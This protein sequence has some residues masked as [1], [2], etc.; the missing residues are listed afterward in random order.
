MKKFILLFGL[1]ILF[2]S[3]NRTKPANT[4]KQQKTVST[5]TNYKGTASITQGIAKIVNQD[6]FICEGGRKTDVGVIKSTDGKEWTV[7]TNT[8]FNNE[9]FLFASDL[10]NDCNGNSYANIEEAISKLNSLNIVE[11]DKDGELFSAYIFADNYFEMYVNGVP[12]GKDKVPFTKFNSSIVRFKAKKPFT[13]AMKLVDWEEGL[14]IGTEKNRRS[15][16]HAGD[17]G[18]VTVV[19]D[20]NNNIVAVTNESW[21]AQT[22]YT[23]P[24]KDLSCVTE[25]GSKRI[26]E[27][28]DET[29]SDDGTLFYG[30]HWELPSGWEKENFDDSDWPNATTYTNETIGVDNKKSYT[31]FTDIFDDKTNDAK[32]IWSYNVVLDNE[33]IVRYTVE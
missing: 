25:D 23:A 6:I 27:N 22:F 3:C 9:D 26:S 2:T 29:D 30:L 10:Y 21:K 31:N 4:N 7:P 1:I 8:N 14:G 5:T 28:C 16:F 13:I 11:I 20:V 17:G 19:K 12:V 18:M 24:I 32:F 15:D 33:V